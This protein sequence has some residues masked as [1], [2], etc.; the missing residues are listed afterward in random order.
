MSFIYKS[1]LIFTIIL[2]LYSA[3]K[4]QL[5]PFDRYPQNNKDMY[6]LDFKQYFLTEKEEKDDL[7][8]FYSNLDRF[9]SL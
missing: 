8:R 1:V 5:K 4:A 2:S 3:G 6:H 7:V 9:S